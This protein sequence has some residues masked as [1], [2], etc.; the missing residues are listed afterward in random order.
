MQTDQPLISALVAD[1]VGKLHNGL[2]VACNG[3]S[4][5]DHFHLA[6]WHMCSVRIRERNE[7]AAL[8]ICTSGGL[9]GQPAVH[10]CLE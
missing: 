10:P 9:A 7:N 8:A 3:L 5:V 1:D 2:P 4:S 6:L